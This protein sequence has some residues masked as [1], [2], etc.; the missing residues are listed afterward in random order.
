MALTSPLLGERAIK[1]GDEVITVAAGFPTTVAPVVQSGAVPVFI[2]VTIP[3]Y[4]IDVS[5]LESALTPKS[6]AVMVAHT[7]GNPVDLSTVKTF[8][9]HNRLWLIEDNCDSLGSVYNLDGHETLTGTIG[10]IG[11]SSF[12]PPHHITT[13]EGGAVYTSDPLLAKIIFSLR[14]WGRDCTCSP[15]QDN[16][17]GHRFDAKFSLLPQGYDHKYVYSHLGYNF[18]ATDMQAAIGLAQLKKLPTF[19]AKRRSN[20]DHLKNELINA[21]IEDKLIL[22]EACPGSKPSWF[23]FIMTCLHPVNRDN[24]VHYLEE[25]GIQ[26][27]MVFAGNLIRQPCFDSLR[28]DGLKYRIIGD[29][30]MTDC[31]MINSFWIGIYPG[32][33]EDMLDFLLQ[34][35]LDAIK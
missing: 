14:D 2:D 15:G 6:K 4:N 34:N 26:T 27:R 7:M 16:L 11:T 29:L 28:S 3:Q 13:G 24:I 18:K 8:C 5:A 1:Q 32:L 23:G 35:I 19:V 25:K 9:T 17:C 30:P 31:V 12:Y 10:D 20:F 21:K 33:T 22:P